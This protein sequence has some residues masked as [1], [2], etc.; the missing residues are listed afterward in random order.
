M[1]ALRTIFLFATIAAS[2][3]VHAQNITLGMTDLE[4]T[5]DGSNSGLI[6]GQAATLTQSATIRLAIFR[7][8][9]LDET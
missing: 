2:M 8:Q 7:N 9:R 3:P 6:L 4:P 1:K 5:L